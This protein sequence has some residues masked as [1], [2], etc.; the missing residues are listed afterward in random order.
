LYGDDVYSLT[1]TYDKISKTFKNR[2][3]YWVK[4]KVVI[5]NISNR[6]MSAKDVSS[7][8]A[9]P[10][11]QGYAYLALTGLDSFSLV[12]AG[13]YLTGDDVVLSV[14]YWKTDKT[15]QNI[16]SQYKIIS[17]DSTNTIPSSI[18][19]KWIDSLCGVDNDGRLVPDPSLPIKL[20]YGIE[21]RPRQGMFVNRLEALKE[22]IEYA[23]QILIKNQIVKNNNI[24]S[25]ESFDTE[26]SILSG[27]YDKILDT[28]AE[29]SYANA[30]N[31]SLPVLI[32]VIVDGKIVD[33]IVQNPGKGYIKTIAGVDTSPFIIIN[34]SGYGAV[35]QSKINTLGQ[36]T[37]ATV[38]SSGEGYNDSNTTCSIRSYS[39][40]V[41]SDM[42]AGGTWSI[43][44]YDS[45]SKLWSRTLTQRYDVR[46]Y[47]SYID[48]FATG[49]NQFTLADFAVNTFADL[50]SLA[51]TIGDNVKVRTAN[52]GGWLLLEKY[53]DSTSIDWTESYRVIGV[54]NGTIK[55][56]SSLYKF[57]NTI[58][59]YDSV[60]YDDNVYDVVASIELRKILTSLKT[61]IF[62]GDL[63][64]EYLNLF[65]N[66]IHYVFSEQ[67]YVDW[68]FKTSFVKAQHNVGNLDQPV[69]Y[70]VDNLSNFEDYINE[71]KP[72]RT[73][74]RE[75][76]SNY[77]G[78]DTAQLPITDFDLMPIYDNGSIGLVNTTIQD[79]KIFADNPKIRDYPWKFWLDNTTF[80][81]MDLVLNDGGSGYNIAPDVKIISNSGTGATARAF[82]NNGK[83]NRIVL[84]TPGT[85]YLS[86]PTIILD[87]GLSESGTA[88]SVSAIIGNSVV[89]STKIAIKFDRHT[90]KQYITQLQQVET[91]TGTGSNLQF[92]L[93]WAPNVKIGNSSV[94]LNGI[95][96]LRELYTLSTVT[97]KYKGY[98]SFTGLLTLDIS[99]RPILGDIVVTY[100]IN[101]ESLNSADRIEFYYSPQEGQLGKDLSQ[102]MTGIDYGGVIVDGLGFN[103]TTGWSSQPYYTD[104]WDSVDSSFDDYFVTV[105]ANIY[106]FPPVSG[107]PFPS[108]WLSGTNVNI[109]HVKNN[110]D[111]YISNGIQKEF[112][113]N[114]L[115]DTPVV[116]TVATIQTSGIETTYNEDGSY[117][118]IL[119]LSDTTGIAVGMGII[120]VGFASNIATLTTTGITSTGSEATITFDAQ[121]TA[122]Y[123]VGQTIVLSNVLPS[124]YNGSHTVTSCTAGN[125]AADPPIPGT[126]SFATTVTGNQTRPG[127]VRGLSVHTVVE[128]PD[129]ETVRLSRAPDSIPAGQL[130]FTFGFAGSTN[131]SVAN[132]SKIHKGDLV[133]CTSVSALL[134]NATVI[135]IIIPDD[136]NIQP[137]VKLNSLVYANLLPEIDLTF[138]RTLVEPN[139]VTIN[140]N[141]TF[142]LVTAPLNNVVINV[143]GKINPVKLDD[144][145][146]GTP[147]TGTWA[148]STS[149]TTGEI[150]LY[151]N[152]K[153]VCKSTHTSSLINFNSDLTL[154]KWREYNDDAIL[155]TPVADGTTNFTITLPTISANR[156]TK[157]FRYRI[158]VVG[159]TDFT[160]I[161]ATSNTINTEFVAI[162]PGTGTGTVNWINN[163][164][165]FI[166]RKSTSDGSIAPAE[167]DYDTSLIGGNLTYTT[168]VGIAADD[169]LVDGDGFVTPTSSPAP[170]EIVPGQVVDTV[171]IKVYDR[172]SSGSATMKVDNFVANGTQRKFTMSQQ[173]NSDKAIIVK[174]GNLIKLAGTD[175]SINYTTKSITFVTPPTANQIVSI[176]NVGFNGSNLL[177]LDYFIGDGTTTEFITKA[178]WLSTITT[179]IYIDGVPST[180]ELFQ[181]DN[182]YDFVNAVGLRFV[183]PPIVGSLINF[184]VVS[185][186][187]QSFAITNTE[188]ITADGRENV[189]PSPDYVPLGTSTYPLSIP[190]GETY[191]LES[192]MLV[193]ANQTVLKGP[194]DNYFIIGP[195]NGKANYQYTLNPANVLPNSIE[196]STINVLANGVMLSLGKDYTVDLSGITIKITKAAYAKYKNT[197]LIISITGNEGYFYNPTTREITFASIYNSNDIIEVISSYNHAILDMQ[198]TEINITSNVELTPG[199]LEFY[200][201]SAIKSGLIQLDRSVI[202]DNYLW[203]IKD[204]TLLVPSIDF[205]VNDDKKS[206]QLA[207][208]PTTNQAITIITFGSNVLSSGIAYQQFKD[209]LN[210]THFKR[211][212]LNKRTKLTHALKWSDT[213]IVVEDATNFDTPNA[214]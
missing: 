181:T 109:Y 166:F 68:I 152:N 36:V 133:T 136:T 56:D 115:A 5:P 52:S 195:K 40:L 107:I 46:K 179:L 93:K 9:N 121:T 88:G 75:Y 158:A 137:Y 76:V 172:P 155:T 123:N 173:P 79:G 213:S 191:P 57:A 50:N 87:G 10:Q 168:A 198:R 122:P 64:Q 84:L 192:S 96:V 174:V 200:Y 129:N 114:P 186:T 92:P 177:D 51:S 119:K 29:L 118:T 163:G 138:T 120:G 211:L 143:T 102:L 148:V 150:V 101:E 117:D 113:Y 126:V 33:I 37:G 106:T 140:A 197:R 42:Q 134:Y 53:S 83:V 170:E 28:D 146:Y 201:Y 86:A 39:V 214:S 80:D 27:L 26:P 59:C 161:G 35:V 2:Y 48:W 32:P 91:F 188:R 135:D 24:S 104:K 100:I 178:P 65:F 212:S 184:I 67:I 8:I 182:S 63:K 111:T 11:G 153:Y 204:N 49:Y 13:P 125:P 203:V 85:G 17:N 103:I 4:N 151:N 12:N 98:A 205:K 20:R 73:K 23:N 169:I 131:L 82:I 81:I 206:I 3:Y 196:L 167:A 72:Y 130:I 176:F 77:D 6:F 31:F 94:T 210:R 54:E 202:D 34:G 160:L 128:V 189:G 71:V 7:L 156:I 110:V 25:L 15:D 185:G 127:I 149:Y 22:L 61:V 45:N 14:E 105:A 157:G 190:V 112:T 162:K 159:T 139:D 175:Y 164:D 44:A 74:V 208:A 16:H 30:S 180:P 141:G 43:Y 90:T 144:P 108:T 55:F 69:T 1:Q 89:R 194:N 95:P 145:A 207:V 165:E 187:Q 18:E 132:V 199:T 124:A 116:T 62:T 147:V 97:S 41:H 19:Q 193:R 38:I 47:W 209:M 66:S 142:V 154:G 171:A 21:N 60:I 70:P 78:M 183:K 58:V 99:L